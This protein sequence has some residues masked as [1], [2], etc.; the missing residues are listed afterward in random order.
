[1]HFK[2]AAGKRARR[3]IMK[4]FSAIAGLLLLV[5]AAAHVYRLYSGMPVVVNGHDIPMWVSWAGALVPGVLG[6]MTLLESRR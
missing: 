6:L 3:K 4:P 1:M 2:G 5:V